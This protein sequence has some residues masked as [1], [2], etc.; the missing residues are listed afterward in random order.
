[1]KNSIRP[2]SLPIKHRLRSGPK[3]SNSPLQLLWAPRFSN[4]VAKP[5]KSGRKKQ[6]R[7]LIRHAAQQLIYLVPDWPKL[8]QSLGPLI[9][10]PRRCPSCSLGVVGLCGSGGASPWK[11]SSPLRLW[12]SHLWRDESGLR[13]ERNERVRGG[14]AERVRYNYVDSKRTPLISWKIKVSVYVPTSIERK[15][16]MKYRVWL[17]TFWIDTRQTTELMKLI[18]NL[19]LWQWRWLIDLNYLALPPRNECRA[20]VLTCPAL[21]ASVSVP[22]TELEVHNSVV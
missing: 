14:E 15:F 19:N 7:V 6:S 11:K 9:V 13:R 5:P 2:N 4:H 1:M 18:A 8:Q 12:P 20:G 16:T 22:P 10:G 3:Q 21:V 17:D